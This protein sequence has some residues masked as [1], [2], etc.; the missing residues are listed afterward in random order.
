MTETP[1]KTTGLNFNDCLS[2]PQQEASAES[3]LRLC[4]EYLNDDSLGR[5]EIGVLHGCM[6][7]TYFELAHE[8]LRAAR[9]AGN[10][11]QADLAQVERDL[12][13]SL[14]QY[15]SA[16]GMNPGNF[17]DHWNR[18]LCYEFLEDLDQALSDYTQAVRINPDFAKGYLYRARILEQQ[19]EIEK[20]KAD[21]REAHRLDPKEPAV[22]EA[23]SRRGLI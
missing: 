1:G 11:S 15:T 13:E 16:I 21:I 22:I 20:A 7:A 6:G 18:G 9:A 17:V 10:P 5:Q 8:R 4:E 12:R 14:Q 2:V 3:R 19:G 23:M